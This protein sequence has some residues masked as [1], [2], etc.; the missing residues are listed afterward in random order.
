MGALSNEIEHI[1]DRKLSFLGSNIR[2]K[3]GKQTDLAENL[4]F[5]IRNKRRVNSND[6]G[7]QG[8]H[9]RYQDP[10]SHTTRM[11]EQGDSA[12]KLRRYMVK[13]SS[14]IRKVHVQIE[15]RSNIECKPLITNNQ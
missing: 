2:H 5:E 10:D 9:T 7:Y 13:E 12:N 3:K 15:M 14:I 11:V 8:Y 6:S 4:C 1:E